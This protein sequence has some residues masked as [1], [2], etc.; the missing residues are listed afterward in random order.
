MRAT[1]SQLI[2]E[3]WEAGYEAR[4][5]SG[6][7]MFGKECVSIHANQDDLWK[8]ARSLSHDLNIPTPNIDQLGLGIVI[9]W[10]S[11]EWPKEENERS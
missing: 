7:G 6:R 10:P 11:Y 8:V 3:L 2:D 5:Y 9:Y 4:S 1:V